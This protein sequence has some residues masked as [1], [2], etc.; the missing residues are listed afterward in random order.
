LAAALPFFGH[1]IVEPVGTVLVAA[2]GRNL[3]NNRVEAARVK[4][5]VT[6]KLPI[7]WIKSLPDLSCADGMKLFVRQLKAMDERFRGDYGVRLGRFVI[8]TVAATFGMRDEDDNAEATK[9]CKLLRFIYEDTGALAD[10]VHHYGKNPESG[11]RGASAWKGSADVVMGVLADIDPL[12]GT[13][14]NRE[15]VFTKSRDGAQGPLSPFELQFVKLGTDQYG[16]DYGSCCVVPTDGQS[17]FNKAAKTTKGDRAF[18]D[19]FGECLDGLSKPIT[20]RAGMDKVRAV[21]V[22]S[23]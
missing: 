6:N 12:S 4:A 5:Q 17:R 7:A 19:A 9:V 2:E 23:E 10:A 22:T 1:L 16:E 18:A 20:P 8:D 3:I 11:L 13:T 21:K 15:L 14:S